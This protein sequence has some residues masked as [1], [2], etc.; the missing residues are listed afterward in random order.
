MCPEVIS[1]YHPIEPLE[2]TVCRLKKDIGSFHF[3]EHQKRG[4]IY[5]L[6]GIDKRCFGILPTKNKSVP[7]FASVILSTRRIFLYF[8]ELIL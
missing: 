8:Q 2:I 7:F 4:Q 6:S 3:S 1:L 5:F